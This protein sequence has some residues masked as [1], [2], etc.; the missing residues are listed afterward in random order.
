MHPN[1]AIE[2]RGGF[3]NNKGILFMAGVLVAITGC[4]WVSPSPQVKQA[5]IMV[6]PPDRVAKCQLLSKTQVSIAD[7]VGFINRV[8]ADVEK[9]LE[10]LA[11]NQAGVQ[12]G[13]T[14]SP[15]NAAMNGTQ[16]FGIYKCLG[17]N[18]ITSTTA[19]SGG[20]TTKTTPYQPPR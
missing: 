8:Q 6:L 3:M 9:D 5:D 12:G 4:T 1:Q 2:R 18:P 20:T 15:L 10:T 13:D 11:M 14:V 17:G 7:R 19:P 16:T